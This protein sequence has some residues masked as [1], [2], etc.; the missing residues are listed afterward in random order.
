MARI[1]IVDDEQLQRETLEYFL[2]KQNYEV[3]TLPSALEAVDYVR[4]NPVDIVVTDQKMPGMSGLELAGHIH[5]HHPNIS[6]VVITAFGSIEDAVNAMKDGVEDYLT[7]PV[8]LEELKIILSRIVEKRHL[9]DENRKLREAAQKIPRLSNVI[10]ESEAMEEV[11]SIAVRAAESSATVLITGE[12]GTGKEVVARAIHELSGRR[13]KPFVAVNCAAIPDSLIESELFGHEKGA[14]TGAEQRRI[15]RFEQADGGTIFLDEVG[16]IPPPIQ[17][18]LLR[19]LQEREF[20][21]VGGSAT[22][23]VDVRVVS[24][25]N[26]DLDK[27]AAEGVFR[28]DLFY[29]LNV[30]G[31]EIP[32][33]RKRK[34]DIP[35]LIEHFMKQYATVHGKHIAYLTPEARDLLVKYSY[36]GNIRELSNIIEQA[37]VLTRGDTIV[38]DDLPS[39]VSPPP[40][41]QDTQKPLKQSVEAVEKRKLFDTLKETGG[42]KSAAARLLGVSEGKIRYLLKKY[43]GEE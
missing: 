27:D 39:R 13:E 25:T 23:Q 20:Q 37:V 14:F 30:V 1:L 40:E 4:S 42:N 2:A 10:Y 33:L 17:V 29:R 38:P 41:S 19:I 26:R 43:G 16:E 6:V 32:P 12:S 11:M 35:P 5:E 28:E 36:P 8:N 15:G 9:I 3:H 24:A 18:K 31:I 34:A 7:K 21:R 22:I